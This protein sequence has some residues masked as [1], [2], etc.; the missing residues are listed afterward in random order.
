[1]KSPKVGRFTV[2]RVNALQLPGFREALALP[3]QSEQTLSLRTQQV[4]M[5][6][7]GLAGY[8]DIFEGSKIIEKLTAETAARARNRDPAARGRLL[9]R[10]FYSQRRPDAP[11]CGALQESRVGRDRANRRQ[12][13]Y[14]R[15]RTHAPAQREHGSRGGYAQ[16]KGTHRVDKKMARGA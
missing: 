3:D 14:R 10:H 1:M 15:S 12:R 16:G 2:E 4:L 9:A 13:V 6:E 8:G 5:H 11:A 7:T